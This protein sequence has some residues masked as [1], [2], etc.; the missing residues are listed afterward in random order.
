MIAHVPK[1]SFSGLSP[2][3]PI[4][5]DHL[6]MVLKSYFDGANKADLK[7]F[8]RVVLATALGTS[9]QWDAFQEDWK[10]TLGQHDVPFLHTTDA[11]TLNAPFSLKDG[12]ND[13]SVD[14]LILDCVRVIKRHIAMPSL[15]PGEFRPGLR[16]VTMTIYLEDYKKAREKNPEMPNSVNEILTSELLGFVFRWGRRIGA[17]YYHLYFDQGEDF[18]GHTRNRMDNKRVRRD[19]QMFEKVVVLAEADMRFTSGLQMADLFAWCISHND[20]S[21]KRLWH[22]ALDDLPIDPSWESIYM[23]QGYLANPT[24]GAFERTKAWGMPQRRL[25]PK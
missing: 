11:I 9:E 13:N 14:D 8:D 24:P 1:L 21:S 18:Y 3:W 17:E 25:E 4:P 5:K 7:Q 15:V 22:R 10:K 12:W 2:F 16:V 20:S 19:V 23:D 6:I